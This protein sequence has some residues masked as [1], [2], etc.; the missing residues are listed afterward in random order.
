VSRAFRLSGAF[1]SIAIASSLLV[2][3]ASL[4]PLLLRPVL[5]LYGVTTLAIAATILLDDPVAAALKVTDKTVHA[6]LMGAGAALVLGA[7]VGGLCL[8]R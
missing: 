4:H 5:L 8:L 2:W 3:L 1:L 6:W 7:G